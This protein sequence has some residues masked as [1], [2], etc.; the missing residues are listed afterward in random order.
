MGA[1]KPLLTAAVTL[2]A[3]GLVGPLRRFSL[4]VQYADRLRRLPAADPGNGV[5][6]AGAGETVFVGGFELRPRL[7]GALLI[8]TQALRRAGSCGD[9]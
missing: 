3:D 4:Q 2:G 8:D 7:G 1:S 9:R 6:H 5:F